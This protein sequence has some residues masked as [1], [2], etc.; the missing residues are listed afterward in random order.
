MYSTTAAAAATGDYEGSC[1]EVR[2][3]LSMTEG[4]YGSKSVELA[5]ELLKF[6]DVLN[7]AITESGK[8]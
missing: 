7:L 6:S 3:C 1:E 4:R 2:E 8:R 5:H